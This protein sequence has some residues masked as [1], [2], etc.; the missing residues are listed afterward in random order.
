MRG[1]VRL[2]LDAGVKEVEAIRLFKRDLIAEALERAQGNQCRAAAL[3]GL[4]RNTLTRQLEELE[5][6]ELP[7]A[8]RRAQK[9]PSLCK[10]PVMKWV[11]TEMEKLERRLA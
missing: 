9:Q 7:G 5:L 2:A 8:L 6:R 4:H 3:L 1:A 11:D 10:R